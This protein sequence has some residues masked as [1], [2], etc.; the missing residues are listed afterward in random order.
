M[1][2]VEKKRIE[3]KDNRKRDLWCGIV[4]ELVTLN[5]FRRFKKSDTRQTNVREAICCGI[6][7]ALFKTSEQQPSKM[8]QI[9]TAELDLLQRTINKHLGLGEKCWIT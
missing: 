4:Y 2:H 7:E 3:Y 1:W 5:W 8:A 9:L 6:D